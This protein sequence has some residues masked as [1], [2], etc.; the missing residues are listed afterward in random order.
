VDQPIS[1]DTVIGFLVATPLF[2]GLDAAERGEVVR[3]MEVQRLAD[4]ER[5][6]HEGEP[7]DAWYVIYEGRAKVLK[8]L[9]S[10]P[11]QIAS[12]DAGACFG[13]M[14]ILDGSAR[15]ATVAAVGPLTVFRFRRAQFEELLEEGSLAAYK[16]VAAM[17]R[18]LSQRQRQLTHELSNLMQ[19]DA[20]S[21]I[22][23]LIDRNK[24]FE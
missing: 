19:N 4:T 3:I 24:V 17:A 6:F 12:L 14:A 8:A 2:D 5:V 20:H 1:L 7:G 18:S 10:G 22:T 9:P 16:L 21:E 23:D 11:V 13:E 15:S